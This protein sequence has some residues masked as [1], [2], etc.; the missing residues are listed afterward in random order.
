MSTAE[1]AAVMNDNDAT[2]PAAVRAA[3]PSIAAAVDAIV[4]RWPR[5]AG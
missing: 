3:L 2:V 5:A 1:L 4:D